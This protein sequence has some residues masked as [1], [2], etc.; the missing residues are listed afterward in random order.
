LKHY[1]K[2]RNAVGS[3]LRS[4]RKNDYTL[5][6]ADHCPEI[7]LVSQVNPEIL[8]YSDYILSMRSEHKTNRQIELAVRHEERSKRGT[9]NQ[10]PTLAGSNY[11]KQGTLR[12]SIGNAGY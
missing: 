9:L 10:M 8:E 6:Q 2:A 1:R 7:H 12:G 4:A 3:L 11:A 5:L